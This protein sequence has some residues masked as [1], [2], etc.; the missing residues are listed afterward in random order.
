MG[1]TL[2]QIAKRIQNLKIK[3]IHTCQEKGFH[4]SGD[5]EGFSKEVSI[6]KIEP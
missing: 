2:I 3:F 1:L 4:H 6:S 5:A